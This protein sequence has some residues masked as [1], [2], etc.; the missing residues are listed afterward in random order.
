[1]Y[2]RYRPQKF[3]DVIGQSHVTEPLMAALRQ[4]RTAHAYLFSGPRGCGKTTSARILARC[5]NCAA[6]PTDTP[7]GECESCRELA[8]NG[9]GSL[10]VVEMDAASHGNVEDARA[11]VERAT[12]APV[13]DR[14]KIF[15]VDEAHMVT[16][17]GFNALLKLVEEPP[18]HVKFVFATTEPEKVIPTIRSR[19]HHYP[20]RL[21]PPETLEEYM[22][23]LCVEE[24][25][26]VG[27]GVLP[28]VVRAGG[29]SVRDSLSVLDQ[30]IGGSDTASV[31]YD[32]AVAL[33]GFTDSA[34][35]DEA[36]DAM[37][38][39]DG[40]ALF[41]VVERLIQSGH[42][43][44]RFVEDLL[45][46][47][48][49]IVILGLV[50]ADAA[51]VFTSVPAD[52]LERMS[53]QADA[54]GARRAS[55]AADLV[56]EAL[57]SMVGATSPRLQLELLCARL[58][59]PSVA[60]AA[61]SGAGGGYAGAGA[62]G[63][64]AGGGSAGQGAGAFPGD[65]LSRAERQTAAEMAAQARAKFAAGRSG[66]QPGGAG[67][68]G[69]GTTAASG[70]AAGYGFGA[71]FGGGASAPAHA[72][73]GAAPGAV[74]GAVP[75][76]QTGSAAFADS[77]DDWGMPVQP[78][79][80]WPDYPAPAQSS[81]ATGGASGASASRPSAD[82]AAGPGGAGDARASGY[83]GSASAGAA[84]AGGGTSASSGGAVRDRWDD[85]LAQLKNVGE[86]A[87]AM[88]LSGNAQPGELE[89]G[90]FSLHFPNEN[91]IGAGM[92]FAPVL[93]EA[94]SG[95][96]GIRAEI[97]CV[98]GAALAPKAEAAGK[99]ANPSATPASAPAVPA[100]S[101]PGASMPAASAPAVPA[102]LALATPKA[103]AST[104]A[105]SGD[106][107]ESE[108]QTEA[109]SAPDSYA[110]YSPFAS[111]AHL[112]QARQDKES[113]GG[114]AAADP[115]GGSEA[116]ASPSVDTEAQA[117]ADDRQAAPASDAEQRTSADSRQSTA[118]NRQ[119][120]PPAVDDWQAAAPA[121]DDWQAPPA[122]DWQAPPPA[123]DWHAAPAEPERTAPPAADWGMPPDLPSDAA[124][125]G[126]S[127]VAH[128][129]ESRGSAP[130]PPS[131]DWGTPQI[132]ESVDWGS[133]EPIAAADGSAAGAGTS[134]APGMRR[135]N[136][137]PDWAS[138]IRSAHLGGESEAFAAAEVEPPS[139]AFV[140]DPD[141]VD[142]SSLVSEDDPMIE[143]SR[144]A[145]LNVVLEMLGGKVIR[146]EDGT[147]EE[148]Q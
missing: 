79:S 96:L 51:D 141:D 14:Y 33:L 70:L 24:G 65:P 62:G 68:A 84:Q 91:M 82:G 116:A 117:P 23:G 78:G 61:S 49:D 85:V 90:T 26:E 131:T 3:Q 88:F 20:F 143:N 87:A 16:N 122:D 145:G 123:D 115:Q 98:P 39:N 1:M 32:S 97:R 37:A 15:I 138:H 71:G 53:A 140:D 111:I 147:G 22:A 55:E 146:E 103:A 76:T 89:G 66:R 139:P 27:D 106:V 45:Q 43:P 54:L 46:R 118:D 83:G 50:G 64:F 74:P 42:A 108:P 19:T 21:V 38:A 92:R 58:L 86:R 40:A 137:E 36:I 127:S 30:L 128:Q 105:D 72:G 109:T 94:I 142:G 95:T 130:L 93:A 63:G 101:A 113:A 57:S 100:E 107:P 104:P 60:P 11:L 125:P 9:G 129:P 44:R 73:A 112:E 7:C 133:P 134:A 34:L 75:G 18:E 28:L 48:R 69:A 110:D 126:A 99:A 144:V 12:F 56:N 119:A 52:Q 6:G 77:G 31:S 41:G 5:L 25:V 59:L 13:R 102:E 114:E 121:V 136:A 4:N 47:M 80:Q 135:G 2:R 120:V 17:Q 148:G 29:G 67:A 8:A 124:G 132:S 35:L 81:S 10:D